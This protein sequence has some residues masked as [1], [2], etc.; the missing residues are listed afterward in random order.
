MTFSHPLFAASVFAAGLALMSIG[1]AAAQSLYLGIGVAQAYGLNDSGELANRLVASAGGGS[2]NVDVESATGG[3]RLSAG[4]RLN[5]MVELEVGYSRFNSANYSFSGVSGSGAAYS[6]VGSTQL[7]GLDAT[8]FLRLPKDTGLDAFFLQVGATQYEVDTEV[9][10]TSGGSTGADRRKED[11]TGYVL[12]LGYDFRR[13][14]GD[15]VDLR[16]GLTQNGRIAGESDHSTINLGV[17]LIR[18]FD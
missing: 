12:G 1:P 15:Q 9:S 7:Q 10:V 17:N 2:A 16:A 5:E 8:A 13:V 18:R 6:G 11:G 14:M 3:G 4:L